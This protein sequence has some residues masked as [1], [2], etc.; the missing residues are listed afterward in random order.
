MS[1]SDGGRAATMPRVAIAILFVAVVNIFMV[2]VK[3]SVVAW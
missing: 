1:F 2:V 3:K